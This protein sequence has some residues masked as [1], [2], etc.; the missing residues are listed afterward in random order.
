[1]NRTAHDPA[2]TGKLVRFQ[3]PEKNL[4]YLGDLPEDTVAGLFGLAPDAYR[5]LLRDLDGQAR[6]AAADLLADPEFAALAARLPFRP[7]ERVAV[8]GESTT[9]D[10]LSWRAILGHL[11]PDTVTLVDLAVS[12]LTT[13]Q[14]LTHLPRL[15]FLRPDRVLCMLGANDAQR[16]A[17]TPEHP[18]GVPLVGRAETERNLRALRTHSGITDPERWIWLTPSAMDHERADAYPHFRRAG[19]G[20]LREDV[21]AVADLVLAL[22]G[23]AVDTRKATRP[24][25]SGPDLHTDDGVHL[26]P[27][28]QRALTEAVV[29]GLT[30]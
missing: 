2:L 3:Q 24:T 13:S 16:L 11:L 21:D 7:G 14:A 4:P 12:G 18:D 9:A 6:R 10:R 1:M 8:L 29:R 17:R 23:T 28:G 5:E 25:A 26:S 19:I 20:W 15:G 27:A 22:P 30:T